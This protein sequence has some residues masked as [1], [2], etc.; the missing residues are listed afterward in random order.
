M[1]N[2]LLRPKVPLHGGR[3]VRVEPDLDQS[4][5]VLLHLG[6]SGCVVAFFHGAPIA[7]AEF[8]KSI[9][10]H[11]FIIKKTIPCAKYSVKRHGSISCSEGC[12]C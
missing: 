8:N 7:G 10:E 1:N 5:L 9:F 11:F 3:C 12:Y 4:L 6:Y 2:G